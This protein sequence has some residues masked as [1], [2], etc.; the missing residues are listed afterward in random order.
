MTT[1]QLFFAAAAAASLISLVAHAFIGGRII[2]APALAEAHAAR[3]IRRPFIY[4]WHFVSVAL[5]A[6]AAGFAWLALSPLDAALAA[7]LTAFAALISLLSVVVARLENASPLSMPPATL[8]AI[9][10]VFGAAG[11]A[12]G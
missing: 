2:A 4:C 9:I 11:I 7:Y 8:G 3:R 12:A 5:G 6:T 10:A 1:Q